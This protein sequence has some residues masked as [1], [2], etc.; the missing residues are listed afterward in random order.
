MTGRVLAHFEVLKKLGAGGMG[1]VYKARDLQLRRIVALKLLP[2]DLVAD[3]ERRRRF[4]QE[5]R[6]ASALND[7]NIV[8][9]Y[10]IGEAEGT[11]YIAMEFVE[12]KTIADWIEPGKPSPLRDVVKYSVQVAGAL[13]KAHAAGI[14]HRDLKPANLIVNP[15]GLVK[16]LDFGLAKLVEPPSIETSAPTETNLPVTQ[17]GVIAGTAAYMSP[18][19]AEGKSLDARSDIFSFGAVLYEMVTGRRAFERQSSVATMAAILH[20]EPLPIREI[21]P[22][23]PTALDQ[24]VTRCLRKEPGRRFQHMD[25]LKVALE[26]LREESALPIRARASVSPPLWIGSLSVILAVAAAL[27]YTRPFAP[28]EVI[29]TPAP[30]TTE[31]GFEQEA[32][33]SPDGN[34]VAYSWNGEKQDNFDIYAKIVGVAS[35]L[36][37]TSDPA[38]DFAPAWSP[39]GRSIAFLRE[40]PQAKAALIVI[41]AIGGAEKKITEC[42]LPG[43]PFLNLA[44]AWSPDGKWLLLSDRNPQEQSLGLTLVS[45]SSGEKQRLTSPPGIDSDA[46]FSADGRSVI[47]VRTASFLVGDL[48]LLHLTA[49]LKAQGDPVR[50]TTD[51][52]VTSRPTWL[53]NGREIVYSS[54]SPSILSLWRVAAAGPASP[55]RL[56]F[57]TPGDVSPSVA[58][59]GGRMVYTHSIFDPNVWRLPLE[60]AGGRAGKPE[61]VILSTQTDSNPQYS[62]DGKRI[63]FESSRTGY[64]EI[65]VCNADGSNPVPLTSFNTFGVVAIPRWSPDGERLVFDSTAAGRY[66]VYMIQ[67]SG[68]QPRRMTNHAADDRIP[69]WSADGR[70]IYFSSNRTGRPEVWKMPAEGGEESQVT[71]ESGSAPA[72]SPDGKDL[73]YLKQ[74]GLW[75][76]PSAGGAESRVLETLY[77]RSYS[78]TRD[79]VYFMKRLAPVQPGP[80]IVGEIQ[81]LRFSTGEVQKLF[82][83]PKPVFVGFSVSPDSRSILYTQIDHQGTDLMQVDGFH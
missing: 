78:V 11:D 7:P 19:Q 26:E 73:Y 48:Y 71:R 74:G 2:P 83:V 54:G 40:L 44:P 45:M 12:G 16:V 34:Q 4:M 29:L 56:A 36:R 13:A 63:A 46:A 65:W 23:A 75:R 39:D 15:D 41:P 58:P 80:G 33:L 18:E 57:S 14:V 43:N 37:L 67:A 30:I 70:W 52:R 59:R 31:P 66:D 20:E 79:G 64:F 47:F 51:N 61:G 55:R 38:R 5:A 62:P 60:G 9:V 22:A 27:W 21:V 6:A 81:F 68:G 35:Q 1:V 50:L 72:E 17:P 10:E 76:M 77:D 53:P 49:D 24:I 42:Y 32:S 8:T 3:A 82:S 28:R 69:N 25:D